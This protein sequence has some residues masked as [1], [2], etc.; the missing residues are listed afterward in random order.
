MKQFLHNFL[1][2]LFV[3]VALVLMVQWGLQLFY[4]P[5]P[6]EEAVA[7][8]G[9]VQAR[10]AY[11]K[12]C[13]PV[14]KEFVIVSDEAGTRIP[15]RVTI[16]RKKWA[17]EFDASSAAL[18]TYIVRA[19]N[20]VISHDLPVY[21]EAASFL[22]ALDGNVQTPFVLADNTYDEHAGI[23][24]ITFRAQTS[25]GTIVKRYGLHDN[26]FLIDMTVDYALH[27]PVSSVALLM[28]QP[29]V[30]A[31]LPAS[32][33][34]QAASQKMTAR[35]YS[36]TA[37]VR[38]IYSDTQGTLVKEPLQ[39]TVENV[40]VLPKIM[41]L[42]DKY[43]VATM[44]PGFE[45][46]LE[47]GYVTTVKYGTQ[48]KGA[49]L[50]LQG[51]SWNNVG[52]WNLRFLVGPQEWHTLQNADESLTGL[53]EYGW[54]TP[55]VKVLKEALQFCYRFIPNYGI[56]IFM[57][58][59]LLNLL[60]MPLMLKGEKGTQKWQEMS[61]KMSHIQ[62]KYKND[63]VR[64]RQ[65]QE[66]LL[67][68]GGLGGGM[69]TSFLM[70]FVQS[71]FFIALSRLLAGYV[72]LYKA[73]FFGWIHDLSQPDPYYTIALVLF[74]VMAFNAANVKEPRQQFALLGVALLMSVIVSQFSAGLGLYIL[75]NM[76]MRALM[77]ASKRFMP[78]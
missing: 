66:E 56:A 13:E 10:L 30:D 59:L 29:S 69:G 17:A 71:I 50:C 31:E 67:T 8:G 58:T 22:L 77:Q 23:T 48:T 68:S 38:L 73:P 16:E 63:P 36:R 20:G 43:T 70:L 14:Q 33:A 45:N 27:K 44:V 54:F 7:S 51:Q 11:E 53:L 26:N 40:V 2:N 19:E 52:S 41:G 47:R 60:L 32:T 1:Q 21:Q 37:P 24:T 72:G 34:A 3:T 18:K 46:S 55:L 42:A 5:A 4:K 61:K 74:F 9:V 78:S 57:V 76:F 12:A 25:Y 62:Q 75:A 35:Y 15:E 65:A 64:L 49:Y 39:G 6:Q 28:Q